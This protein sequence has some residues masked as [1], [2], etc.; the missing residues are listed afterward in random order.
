MVKKQNTFSLP[1]RTP[2]WSIARHGIPCPPGNRFPFK[3]SSVRVWA[4]DVD[5]HDYSSLPPELAYLEVTKI[6]SVVNDVYHDWNVAR[7]RNGD[8]VAIAYLDEKQMRDIGCFLIKLSERIRA[9]RRTKR[10]K[11]PRP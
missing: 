1:K 7:A 4:V 10:R 2:S 3:R 8:F 5:G 6:G 9:R 11:E